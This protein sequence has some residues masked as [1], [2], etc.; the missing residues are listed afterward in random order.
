MMFL[1]AQFGTAVIPL[2]VTSEKDIIKLGVA[3]PGVE[4]HID[5][6]IATVRF[7]TMEV[8]CKYEALRQRVKA[9]VE[10]AIDTVAPFVDLSKNSR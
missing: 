10:R 1:E 4:I 6:H 5:G 3:V 7:E 8:E 9:V 2:P